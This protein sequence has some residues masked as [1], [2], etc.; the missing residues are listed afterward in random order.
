MKLLTYTVF[1][2]VFFQFIINLLQKKTAFSKNIPYQAYACQ[3][4]KAESPFATLG[5]STN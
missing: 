1:P 4:A 2:F 3:S 5:S